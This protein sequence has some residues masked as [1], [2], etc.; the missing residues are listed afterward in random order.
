L[1]AVQSEEAETGASSDYDYLLGMGIWSLTTEKIS[2]LRNQI[3]EKEGQLRELLETTPIEMWERD[4]DDLTAAWEKMYQDWQEG[5]ATTAGGARK[6]SATLKTRK[7]LGKSKKN[8]QDDS[9]DEFK[10]TVAAHKNKPVKEPTEHRKR[11]SKPKPPPSDSDDELSL[12]KTRKTSKIVD[13]GKGKQSPKRGF[14]DLEE[15]EEVVVVKRPKKANSEKSERKLDTF[16]GKTSSAAGTSKQSKVKNMQPRSPP[17]PKKATKAKVTVLESDDDEGDHTVE[18]AEPKKR[19]ER[20]AAKAPAKYV[21]I[22]SDGA[23]WDGAGDD[24]ESFAM[25]D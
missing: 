4:L 11:A 10:P 5:K 12:E 23:G 9:D 13:K 3:A 14:E 6:K 18:A 24:D 7:S 22:S 8:A 1:A 21:E 25:D 15:G 16:F 20:R 19:S 2:R 17:K